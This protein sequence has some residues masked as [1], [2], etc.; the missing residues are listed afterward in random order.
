MPREGLKSSE[1]EKMLG[2]KY[3]ILN[4]QLFRFSINF[5]SC[6]LDDMTQNNKNVS[7]IPKYT[8]GKG[9]HVYTSL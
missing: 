9:R 4:I 7:L 1:E 5:H 8:F 3:R 2:R 6:H